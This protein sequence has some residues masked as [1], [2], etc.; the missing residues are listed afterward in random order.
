MSYKIKAQIKHGKSG[1]I[2]KFVG[3]EIVDDD[4]FTEKEKE[5][6]IPDYIEK[7]PEN[8]SVK[9]SSLKTEK[10][11][12]LKDLSE[13]TVWQ[14]KELLENEYDITTLLKYLDQER[15]RGPEERI[16]LTRYIDGKVH[17]LTGR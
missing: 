4:F 13:M 14:C 15:A 7:I 12:Q 5:R 17:E 8:V 3:G 10:I 1:K 6:L 11:K 9:K 2:Y 16:T